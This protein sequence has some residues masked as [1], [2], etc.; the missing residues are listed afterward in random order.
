MEGVWLEFVGFPCGCYRYSMPIGLR[1]YEGVWGFRVFRDVGLARLLE[2]CGMIPSFD[3]FLLA[4]SDP[5][6]F[7][8]S[9]FHR[10]EWRIQWGWSGCPSPEPGLGSWF[11]CSARLAGGG[12]W[13]YSYVCEGGL[14]GIV[15][16]G[17]PP[18]YYRAYGCIVELL[19]LH[20][21]VMSGVDVEV[22]AARYAEGLYWCVVRSAPGRGDL[23]LEAWRLLQGIRAA[24]GE[25]RAC[26]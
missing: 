11:Y 26:S 20:S 16:G 21:K 10:L 3:L 1:D 13:G 19:V 7:V 6:V 15:K 17:S 9:Y 25:A 2:S 5:L 24:L 4:P 22:D 8:E 18:S 12:E 14:R 23:W